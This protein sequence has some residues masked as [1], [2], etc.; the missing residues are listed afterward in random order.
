MLSAVGDVWKEEFLGKNQ[1]RILDMY[2][3][4]EINFYVCIS[5]LPQSKHR[6]PITM[7][8]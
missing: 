7:S 1:I 6:N 8:R 5:S 4:I 2:T 3:R